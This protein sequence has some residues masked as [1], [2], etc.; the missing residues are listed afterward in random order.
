MLNVLRLALE[1]CSSTSFTWSFLS[2]A[3]P[4]GPVDLQGTHIT[5]WE[6]KRVRG[7]SGLCKDVLADPLLVKRV[8]GSLHFPA[9]SVIPLILRY[10]GIHCFPALK[11][12]QLWWWNGPRIDQLYDTEKAKKDSHS[13]PSCMLWCPEQSNTYKFLST[14]LHC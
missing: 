2:F 11:K 12:K 4:S 7:T 1:N 13:H 10:W 3:L 8:I 14:A 6:R 9:L 5:H